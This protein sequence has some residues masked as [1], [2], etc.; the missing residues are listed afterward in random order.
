MTK[1][2]MQPS[3]TR[4]PSPESRVPRLSLGLWLSAQLVRLV[5][6]LHSTPDA[7]KLSMATAHCGYYHVNEAVNQVRQRGERVTWEALAGY[8]PAATTMFV[9]RRYERLLQ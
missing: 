1:D 6:R 5:W 2:E 4:I 3:D 9:E 8:L 7:V